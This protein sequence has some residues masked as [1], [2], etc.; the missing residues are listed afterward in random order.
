MGRCA[1]IP[2]AAWVNLFKM[3]REVQIQYLRIALAC[4]AISVHDRIADQII[5]TWE[6]LNE[7]EG[8]FSLKDAAAI[9]EKIRV[10]YENEKAK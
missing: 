3:T 8:E 7:L 6:R 2:G 9:E 5:E 10:K 1:N 4:Q